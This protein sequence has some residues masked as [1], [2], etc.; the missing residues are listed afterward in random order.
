MSFPLTIFVRNLHYSLNE[1]SIKDHFQQAGEIDTIDLFKDSN[2][3]FKGYAYITYKK[4]ESSMNSIKMF[5]NTVFKNRKLHLQFHDLN[6]YS[7][8]QEKNNNKGLWT[9]IK[10]AL[11]PSKNGDNNNENNGRDFQVNKALVINNN[12]VHLH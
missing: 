5:H 7:S 1:S 6:E 3:K 9:G 4:S 10:D 11:I 12:N 2:N 8:P